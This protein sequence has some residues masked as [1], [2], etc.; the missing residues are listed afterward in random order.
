M[1]NSNYTT[2]I[3]R[4]LVGLL[5]LIWIV[6][7]SAEAKSPSSQY[8]KLLVEQYDLD[9]E[10][11]ARLR[12]TKPAKR[13]SNVSE[14]EHLLMVRTEEW[15]SP[16][17]KIDAQANPYTIVL[18]ITGVSIEKGESATMWQG[19]WVWES[20]KHGEMDQVGLIP[21]L[22]TTAKKEGELLTLTSSSAPLTFTTNR[23]ASIRLGMVNVRNMSITGVHVEVWSGV[24]RTTLIEGLIAFRWAL[25]AFVFFGLGWWVKRG[26]RLH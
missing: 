11:V 12:S 9:S 18:T 22:A 3:Q 10:T 14:L 2:S 26:R 7:V 8:G 15:I 4:F 16:R 13:Q 20:V 21:S 17:M 1:P 19:G 23:E 5:L 6:H 24:A 25:V